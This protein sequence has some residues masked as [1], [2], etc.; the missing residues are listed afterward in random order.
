MLI[1]A[2]AVN[3]IL[4][5][6]IAHIGD[7]ILSFPVIRALK[8]AYPKADIDALVSTPQGEVA[9]YNP[10]VNDVLFYNIGTWQQDRKNLLNLIAM[11]QRQNYDLAIA[12]SFGT[13]DPM[14]AF[15]SGARYRVG[16]EENSLGNY[17]T[18]FVP[19]S[20]PKQ[21]EARHQ[22]QILEVLKIEY[23]D[24]RIDF[25][26]TPENLTS[27]YNKIPALY[28][29]QPKVV[30]CPISNYRQKNWTFRGNAQVLKALAKKVQF[31]LIGETNQAPYLYQLNEEA[32]GR[33]E[34]LGGY[35]TLGEIGALIQ[36]S[37][38]LVT[39][40]TGPMHIAQAFSTPVIALFGP[41]DPNMWGPRRSQDIVIR[42]SVKCSPC[43]HVDD[44]RQKECRE[45]K[46]MI[47]INPEIVINAIEKALSIKP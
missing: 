46:C 6:N 42:S 27:I 37:D 29:S 36:S 14:L 39:V 20:S 34:V 38:L 21:H 7:I 24:S 15:L 41:T 9:F 23:T 26:V 1:P 32:D 19:K 17:L 18:H 30:Y 22:L 4:F 5:I 2:E 13:V 31:Y 10:Y 47:N 11:L 43:W 3:K 40:D 33:A 44:E 35:L 28:T 16:F 25:S 8:L 45:P 12:S